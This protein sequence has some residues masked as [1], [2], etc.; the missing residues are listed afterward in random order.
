VPGWL[1]SE[2]WPEQFPTDGARDD[3]APD[4][5]HPRRV[6]DHIV[7]TSRVCTLNLY[8]EN[9][10]V[11]TLDCEGA[12][13]AEFIRLVDANGLT[14]ELEDSIEG[15]GMQLVIL[16]RVTVS[17]LWRGLRLGPLIAALALDTVC[18]DARLFACSPGAFGLKQGTSERASADQVRFHDPPPKPT[19]CRPGRDRLGWSGS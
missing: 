9:H 17:P 2:L 15:L 19:P 5:G 8:R 10:L 7:A 1:S 14:Q 18:A 11:E 4:A 3:K 16:D 13:L 12:D 6:E